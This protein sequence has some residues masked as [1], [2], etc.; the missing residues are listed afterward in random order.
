M[1]IDEAFS[2]NTGTQTS[3]T[4]LPT[5]GVSEA[6]VDLDF[7]G[8]IKLQYQ[9]TGS[10]KWFDVFAT[11]GKHAPA[12]PDGTFATPLIS[13]DLTLTYRFIGIGVVGT[14]NVYFGP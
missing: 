14:P 5:N 6:I 3:A 1:G 10:A 11:V 4:T 13:A 2:T 7:T 12:T 9:R 8:T